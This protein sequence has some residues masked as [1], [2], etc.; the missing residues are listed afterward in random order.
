[1]LFIGSGLSSQAGYPGWSALITTLVDAAK[2]SPN[3]RTGGIDQYEVKKDYFTLA[4]FARSA[5]GPAQF[6]AVIREQLG[7]AVKPT[8]AHRVISTTDYRGLI[9]TNYDRLLETTITQFRQWTPNTFTA[10]SISS[11]AAA[12]YNPE[13]F[14]FKLHGDIGSAESIVLTSR[15]Y[16]RLI[17]RNPHARSFLQAV[18]LNYTVLFIGYSLGDPDFQLIL[19]ELTLIFQNYIPTHFALLPEPAEFTVDHLLGKMNIQTIPY[20]TQEEHKEALE[21][22]QALQNAAPYAVPVT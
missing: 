12:L 2:Q 8:E 16:D 1:M 5:L 22:L 17:L 11:L 6:T 10:D 4:E 3:A 9:T 7:K 15:D 18:F 13:F 20:S 14:I 21:V 19:S